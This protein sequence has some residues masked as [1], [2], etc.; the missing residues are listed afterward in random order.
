MKKKRFADGDLVKGTTNLR[1]RSDEQ[2]A[3]TDRFGN[4]KPGS[5]AARQEQG[6]KNL[7]SVKG[8]FS[9]LTGKSADAAPAAPATYEESPAAKYIKKSVGQESTVSR[10][11]QSTISGS[12]VDKNKNYESEAAPAPAPTPAPTPA[13]APAARR[14]PITTEGDYSKKPDTTGT[15]VD[16]EVKKSVAKAQPKIDAAVKAKKAKEAETSKSK[17]SENPVPTNFGKSVNP[18]Q[19]KDQPAPTKQRETYRDLKGKVQYKEET[20]PASE[21][22]FAPQIMSG[23]KKAGSAISN[24][25]YETPTE[26]R[27]RREKEAKNKPTTPYS[28]PKNA[29]EDQIRDTMGSSMKRG[30]AVKKMASGG[31]TSRSSASS[32]GD[33][34][35]SRGKTR[36]KIC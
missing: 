33:G 21:D 10:P 25:E 27:Y 34:I 20:K 17:K 24:F 8:F 13:P 14:L 28:R 35:A 11:S 6:Q 4:Y 1:T 22:K 31:M 23:L 19:K 26:A 2:I 15:S 5:Y 3:D 18:Y 9:K 29:M 16:E 32:R 12:Q 30:G 7:D 36:G